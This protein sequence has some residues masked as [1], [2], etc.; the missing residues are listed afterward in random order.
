MFK[1]KKTQLISDDQTGPFIEVELTNENAYVPGYP[2]EGTVHLNAC[3]DLLNTERV[4]IQLLGE[5]I[6][7][8]KLKKLESKVTIIDKRFTCY[9]YTHYENT[10]RK[11]EYGY[12]F[13]IHLPY[14]L[15][16][17]HL[18]HDTEDKIG[19]PSDK[20]GKYGKLSETRVQYQLIARVEGNENNLVKKKKAEIVDNFIGSRV[21]TC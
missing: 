20:G 19:K 17:S 8:N 4:S 18:C 7:V 12:P 15:P 6:T 21:F 11:G 16:S 1:K 14:W 5:E 10:I 2:M 3:Q 13:K 9:D